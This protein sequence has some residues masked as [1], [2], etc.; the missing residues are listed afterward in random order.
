MFSLTAP[1]QATI[2]GSN[3]EREPYRIFLIFAL[4]WVS[5]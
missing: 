1:R 5:Y 3:H 2:L 4:C